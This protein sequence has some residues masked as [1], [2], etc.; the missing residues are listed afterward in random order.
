MSISEERKQKVK[1][2]AKAGKLGVVF[3]VRKSDT[4]VQMNVDSRYGVDPRSGKYFGVQP[5]DEYLKL[6]EN[7]L[8]FC[9]L[10]GDGSYEL[11]RINLANTP[12]QL[13]QTSVYD[14]DHAVLRTLVFSILISTVGPAEQ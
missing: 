12:S 1:D 9:I 4:F 3:R 2:A 5:G 13:T 8:L 14:I 11:F 7:H 10:D 6:S